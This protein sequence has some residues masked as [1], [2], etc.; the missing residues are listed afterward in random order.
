MQF[1]NEHTYAI[2]ATT[3]YGILLVALKLSLS[4]YRV[5]SDKRMW[6][7]TERLYGTLEGKLIF[8][9][10]VTVHRDKFL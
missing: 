4:M 8:D 6:N 7:R 1:S 2:F 3:M 9:V 5:K 10:Q